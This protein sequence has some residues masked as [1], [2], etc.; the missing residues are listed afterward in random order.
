M[1]RGAALET[2]VLRAAG[3]VFYAEGFTATGVDRVCEA[4]GISKRTL[5]KFFGSKDELIARSLAQRDAEIRDGLLG[6]ADAATDDPAGR[7][8]AVFSALD[9]WLGLDSFRG[10][11][12]LNAAAELAA[13]DHPARVV[14]VEHKEAIRRWFEAAATDAAAADPSALSWQLMLLFDGA[15]A[16]AL[17]RG[18]PSVRD[19]AARAAATLVAAATER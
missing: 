8:V 10:C 4:A 16:Q 9:E 13:P 6:S 15:I 12:Y 5:Y 7:L 2:A 19:Q 1:V 17:V 14:V 11:P 3:D 18:A